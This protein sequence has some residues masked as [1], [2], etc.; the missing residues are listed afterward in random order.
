MQRAWIQHHASEGRV[1]KRAKQQRLLA[2]LL[3]GVWQ[4]CGLRVLPRDVIKMIARMIV[5]G[6]GLVVA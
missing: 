4:R 6:K 3:L 1:F 5:D 2:T